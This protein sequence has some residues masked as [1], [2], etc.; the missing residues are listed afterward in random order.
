[1]N[2][3]V[4][5]LVAP[6]RN[7]KSKAVPAKLAKNPSAPQQRASIMEHYNLAPK[8]SQTLLLKPKVL[9]ST[10][11]VQ[12]L[13]KE[14]LEQVFAKYQIKTVTKK[15]K[16][17]D[18]DST[19]GGERSTDC[20]DKKSESSP[21]KVQPQNEVPQDFAVKKLDFDENHEKK[22][23]IQVEVKV[24]VEDQGGVENLAVEKELSEKEEEEEKSSIK[25]IQNEKDINS[26]ENEDD[27]DDE[28]PF[29]NYNFG[30]EEEEEEKGLAQKKLDDLENDKQGQIVEEKSPVNEKEEKS[31][32]QKSKE[33][34]KVEE[35]GL[36][37]GKESEYNLSLFDEM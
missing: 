16:A 24:E 13:T 1:V 10:R 21:E 8:K 28:L 35:E 18:N 23:D 25:I 22:Q 6:Y 14:Q 37:E 17:N 30:E 7:P 9:T 20:R 27:Q 31:P 5:R 34:E 19:S 32:S 33:K 11:K 3:T 36:S 2:P 15:E 4:Q 26:V 29:K 12:P